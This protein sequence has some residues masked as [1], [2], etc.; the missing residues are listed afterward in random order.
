MKPYKCPRCPKRFQSKKQRDR[1]A[2]KIHGMTDEELE[3]LEN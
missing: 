2:K 1:H 3:K